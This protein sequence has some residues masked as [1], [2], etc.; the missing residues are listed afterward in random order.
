MKP[1]RTGPKE[2]V[3]SPQGSGKTVVSRVLPGD[4]LG[5]VSP[6]PQN[7]RGG[8]GGRDTETEGD[9]EEIQKGR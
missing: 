5:E 1:S 4:D 2:E 6:S 7:K 9:I 3:R 8:E